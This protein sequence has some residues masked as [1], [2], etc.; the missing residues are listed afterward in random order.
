MV[1][2]DLGVD[3]PVP[4]LRSPNSGTGDR[5]GEGGGG[6]GQAG[7]GGCTCSGKRGCH[8]LKRIVLMYV[9]ILAVL[10]LHCCTGFLSLQSTGLPP[11]AACWLL[12]AEHRLLAVIVACGLSPCGGWAY[13]FQVTWDLPRSGIEPMS[14]ALAGGFF[15]TEPPCM[16]LNA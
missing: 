6:A 12:V 2:G 3:R 14:P 1:D 9:C 4:Q 7:D 13:L 10:G 16:S 5:G 8:F 11:V 15:T